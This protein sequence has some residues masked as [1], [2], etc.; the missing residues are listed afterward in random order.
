MFLNYIGK[1]AKDNAETLNSFWKHQE[2]K[3]EQKP[4]LEIIKNGTN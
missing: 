3:K 2:L 4:K 1:T